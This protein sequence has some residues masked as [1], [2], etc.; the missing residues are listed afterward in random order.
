M[1]CDLVNDE[2]QRLLRLGN[3]VGSRV[4]EARHVMTRDRH[5]F[6]GQTA[7]ESAFTRETGHSLHKQG[8]DAQ[9]RQWS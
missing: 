1:R 8:G 6:V 9:P 4:S 7:R 3:C 5:V 2:E